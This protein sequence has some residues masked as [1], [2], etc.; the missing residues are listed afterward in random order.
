[1]LGNEIALQAVF[2]LALLLTV[3][4]IDLRTRTIPDTLNVL[5]ALTSFFVFEPWNL[6]GIFT[7]LPFLIAAVFCGGM[8]GGDI[9]MMA[10]CG[11]V[12]GL[13]Y[14]LFAEMLGL[15]VMLGF[16]ATYYCIQKI[17]KRECVKSF[18]L[19]PFLSIGCTIA[20]FIKLG[21]LSL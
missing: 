20:Y 5:I 12:L 13:P 10:A 19:A 6:I 1:M 7:A 14:G 3:S 18:P 9:K 2:F 17:R 11:V 4:V 15:F 8:G 21:G 16:Y